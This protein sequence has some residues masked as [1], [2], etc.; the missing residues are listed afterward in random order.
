MENKTEH[1][2]EAYFS[3]ALTSG[4]AAEV[5]TL[6]SDDP[7]FAAEFAWRKSVSQAVRFGME[8][9][10]LKTQLREMERRFRLRRIMLRGAVAVLVIVAVVTAILL[11]SRSSTP[12]QDP[13]EQK[14]KN[15]TLNKI[16]PIPAN[17]G[18]AAAPLPEALPPGSPAPTI[19]TDQTQQQAAKK[20][21]LAQRAMVDTAFFLYPNLS[22]LNSAGG[23]EEEKEMAMDA[24][25]LYDDADYAQA[26]KAFDALVKID[27]DNL[28][29]RFYHGVS[30]LGYKQFAPAE[31]ALVQVTRQ[32]SKY[33]TPAKFYLGLAQ[34][35]NGRY[36]QGR[37]SLL[38]YL[39]SET[40]E[41]YRA[42]ARKVLDAMK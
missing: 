39:A 19:Q 8:N 21:L 18:Q 26:A 41:K 11:L 36:E 22:G 42:K 15:D 31:R 9:D 6:L 4:E 20:E 5:K 37:R 17:P 40:D 28:E 35:G 14:G 7:A 12:E 33:Q 3:N 30:L 27:P 2:L 24:F 23:V 38:D 1:L 10:P 25:M 13:S 32:Q 29:Y 34:I 16:A